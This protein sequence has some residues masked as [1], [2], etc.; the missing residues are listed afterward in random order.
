MKEYIEKDKLLE[1]FENLKKARERK[2][3]CSSRAAMEYDAFN[4]VTTVIERMES[5]QIED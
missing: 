2:K 4:Y 5:V 1:V 3:N